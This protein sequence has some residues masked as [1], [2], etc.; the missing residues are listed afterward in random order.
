[1]IALRGHF[2]DVGE[3]D[4]MHELFTEDCVYDLTDIGFGAMEGR[5]ALKRAALDLGD[6][7]PLAHHVTNTVVT[8]GDGDRAQ[9]V[10]KAIAVMPDGTCGSGTYED[11][12]LRDDGRWLIRHRRIRL[13]RKPLTP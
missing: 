7:N 13:R 1:M 12:L 2:V 3:L 5:A 9:A 4:R 11:T 10:S 8:G 6:R